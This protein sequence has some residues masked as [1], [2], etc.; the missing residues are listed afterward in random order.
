MPSSTAY[1]QVHKTDALKIF[2]CLKVY[3]TAGKTVEGFWLETAKN[4][5]EKSPRLAKKI[6]GRTGEMPLLYSIYI[7]WFR[8]AKN[9]DYS[10]ASTS[11]LKPDAC[12]GLHSLSRI[13]FP[14]RRVHVLAFRPPGT[15]GR[16]PL[17]PRNC[18]CFPPVGLAEWGSS[19]ATCR[20]GQPRVQRGTGSQ[21]IRPLQAGHIDRY[22]SSCSTSAMSRES[23]REVSLSIFPSWR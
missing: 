14:S 20:P 21:V 13:E 4:F 11:I 9:A 7:V 1:L 8:D 19:P 3:L 2:F 18:T 5:S 22:F 6:T 16:W 12:N 23:I 10:S 15:C 17:C